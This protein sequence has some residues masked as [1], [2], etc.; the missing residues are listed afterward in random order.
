[1]NDKRVLWI[2]QTALFIALLIV[3]QISTA[4]MGN[5]LITGSLVNLVLIISVLSYGL[6]TGCSIALLSPL[7]AK[8]FGIGPLWS[9][10]PFIILGN[11][12]LV[13]IY[14]LVAKRIDALN[15]KKIFYYNI[16]LVIVAALCKC[17]VLYLGIVKIMVPLF[18]ELPAKQAHV[19]SSMF[20]LPQFFTALVGGFLALIIYQQLKK[21]LN[22]TSQ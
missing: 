4:F 18:L 7:I 21:I 20:S 1:M 3:I 16:A 13:M 17:I 9:I 6:L 19:I 14:G 11:V 12:V 2:V 5:T 8:L 10:I 15:N 22:N